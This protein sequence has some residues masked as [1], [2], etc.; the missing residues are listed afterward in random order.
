MTNTCHDKIV[1]SRTKRLSA[2][3]PSY[4]LDSIANSS[5]S[6]SSNSNPLVKVR[7]R[8]FL[9]TQKFYK[10]DKMCTWEIYEYH[11]IESQN[12]YL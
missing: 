11:K 10:G 3:E 9:K 12:L 4:L 1:Y 7:R 8:N 2:S 5:S 6:S